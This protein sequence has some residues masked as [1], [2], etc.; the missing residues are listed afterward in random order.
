M[1]LSVRFAPKPKT[2]LNENSGGSADLCK[3]YGSVDLHNTVHSLPDSQGAWLGRVTAGQ[4]PPS[5]SVAEGIRLLVYIIW[6]SAET[7][8][9]DIYIKTCVQGTDSLQ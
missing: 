6:G 5:N 9:L 4:T 7:E 1:Y 2:D 3:K 8:T